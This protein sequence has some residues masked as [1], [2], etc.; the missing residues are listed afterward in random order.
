VREEESEED[1]RLEDFKNLRLNVVVSSFVK[2]GGGGGDSN[3]N[4]QRN[5]RQKYRVPSP[6]YA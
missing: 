6:S 4:S 5:K 1:E 2:K 3:S